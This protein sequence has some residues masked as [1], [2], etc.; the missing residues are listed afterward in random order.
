MSRLAFLLREALVSL[1]RNLLVVA[2][3]I[4]AVFISLTLAFGA[5]VVNEWLRINTLAWQEG[6]HVI[7]FLKD[8]GSNGVPA[9]AHQALLDEVLTWE[10]VKQPDGAFYVDKAQA[11]VEFQEIFAG[12][13]EMLEIDPTILPA[14]IRIELEAIELHQSVKFKLEQQQQ[15]VRKVNTAAVQ[16]EQLQNLSGVLNVLGI[17][18]AVVLGLS[19][20]VL[21]SNT[22]RLAIY[23]RRDEVE[24]MKLVGASNWYIRIPF[25]LEGLIEGVAGAALGV[26][27]VWLAATRL[28]RA[29]SGFALFRFDVSNDFFFRWGVLFLLFGAA[30]GVI[31]S[32]LGL[33]RYLRE[34]DGIGSEVP[35]GAV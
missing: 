6:V 18:L 23:A 3:A 19:A 33:S 28:A 11:W 10:E 32:L 30:A 20:V 14:S 12:Q 26:F 5:L 16:I 25:L 29:S 8:E 9:G 4:L 21:I 1:K 24:I 15:V 35:T 34:A 17:G 31:G 22:I 7:A 27:T 13:D 2:G